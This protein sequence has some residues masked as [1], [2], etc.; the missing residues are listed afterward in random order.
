MRKLAPVL[1]LLGAAI[2]LAIMP[3][4]AREASAALPVTSYLGEIAGIDHASGTVKV[5]TSSS[6]EGVWSPYT[7]SLEAEVVTGLG[8]AS[9]AVGDFVEAC[10]FGFT[11][12]CYKWITFAKMPPGGPVHEIYGDPTWVISPVLGDYRFDYQAV[13]DCTAWDGSCN[14]DAVHAD[15]VV[16]RLGEIERHLRLYSLSPGNSAR[17]TSDALG[18]I[19]TLESGRAPAY[20]VCTDRMCTGVQ[21][22]C[23]FGIIIEETQNG[24]A[25]IPVV[26]GISTWGMFAAA[27]VF[28]SVLVA[29]LGRRPEVGIR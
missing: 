11:G 5:L 16:S 7:A 10:S 27:G 3:P 24:E 1:I 29:A 15:V 22:L 25:P 9:L 28:L 20:P 6:W 2:L 19:I 23:M 18:C 8:M 26:P 13:P 4:S 17:F 21:P 12:E 14:C